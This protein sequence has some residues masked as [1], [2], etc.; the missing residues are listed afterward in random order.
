MIAKCRNDCTDYRYVLSAVSGLFQQLL[1]L[2]SHMGTNGDITGLSLC[3]LINLAGRAGR[4]GSEYFM[5]AASPIFIQIGLEAVSERS[6]SELDGMIVGNMP[7]QGRLLH[8]INTACIGL[9]WLC[10]VGS[11]DPEMTAVLSWLEDNP[12]ERQQV[13]DAITSP[14]IRSALWA[15]LAAHVRCLHEVSGGRAMAFGC[16][17]PS[18]NYR[19]A[20]DESAGKWQWRLLTGPHDVAADDIRKELLRVLST[21]YLIPHAEEVWKLHLQSK[22]S[23]ENQAAGSATASSSSSSSRTDGFGLE[24]SSCCSSRNET[25]SGV[26]PGSKTV[27]SGSSSTLSS[28]S[29]PRTPFGTLG[30]DED[31]KQPMVHWLFCTAA[32]VGGAGNA[33]N[34]SASEPQSTG[35]NGA[36]CSTGLSSGMFATQLLLVL[37]MLV[38]T[39]PA[40]NSNRLSTSAK[41]GSNSQLQ[42]VTSSSS[43]SR[44]TSSS[45]S[46][47]GNSSSRS[48][49]SDEQDW[50]HQSWLL[51][52]L[53]LLQQ[54]DTEAK[55]QLME[56]RGGLLL[57][58]LYLAVVTNPFT[59]SAGEIVY[60]DGWLASGDGV[61]AVCT[62][63][64]DFIVRSL[65]GAKENSFGDM[66]ELGIVPA[67]MLYL[68]ERLLQG[69]FYKA[70]P[71]DQQLMEESNFAHPFTLLNRSGGLLSLHFMICYRSSRAPRTSSC[72]KRKPRSSRYVLS[73]ALNPR[74]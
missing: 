72:H 16:K 26:M 58:L 53:G 31:E 19:A 54:A 45:S 50:S 5:V 6:C 74:P 69:L 36:S 37:D 7:C 65:P 46:V 20:F 56:Q 15:T 27:S 8:V 30:L 21:S 66:R 23:L 39:W 28:C 33:A 59:V 71:A 4:S 11:P 52:L 60:P 1:Y 40:A 13:V 24:S 55:R 9:P 35:S 70:L 62:E 51:L 64:V 32:A 25:S 14:R 38:L 68:V 48:V 18:C 29:S 10:K 3:S 63:D 43:S 67:C 34:N 2:C 17:V 47:R 12:K 41:H 61:A 49:P 57:Q 42:E 73:G 44:T 22:E